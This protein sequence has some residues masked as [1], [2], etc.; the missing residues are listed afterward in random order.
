[1]LL[2]AE[3]LAKQPALLAKVVKDLQLA[4]IRPPGKR[5]SAENG[6]PGCAPCVKNAYA[7]S[8]SFWRSFVTPGID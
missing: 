4:L 3:L 5:R 6:M 2:I 7:S 1:M 8:F